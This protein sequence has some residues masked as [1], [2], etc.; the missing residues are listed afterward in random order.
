MILFQ[1]IVENRD[2]DAAS[3]DSFGPSI[4][5]VHVQTVSPVLKER[6]RE[7]KKKIVKIVDNEEKEMRKMR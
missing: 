1:A 3:G 2:Y 4:L 6:S 7:R 5:H